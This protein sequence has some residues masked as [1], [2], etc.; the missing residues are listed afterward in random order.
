MWASRGKYIRAEPVSAL[1]ARRWWHHVGV[2]PEL[3]EQLT[4]W[5]PGERSPDRVDPLVW[6]VS[7]LFYPTEEADELLVYEDRVIISPY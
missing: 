4:T 6:A 5:V 3:K 2:F 1:Y 7:A